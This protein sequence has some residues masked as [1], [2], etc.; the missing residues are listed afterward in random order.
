MRLR[1]I[2]DAPQRKKGEDI[3]DG[4]WP[5]V[6][7]GS[8]PKTANSTVPRPLTSSYVVHDVLSGG[9][10]TNT[11]NQAEGEISHQPDLLPWGAF[12]P[13]EEKGRSSSGRRR[14][15]V[16]GFNESLDEE[17]KE[18]R[19]EKEEKEKEDGQMREHAEAVGH[20]GGG[21][22]DDLLADLHEPSFSRQE[23]E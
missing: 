4:A 8:P 14:S 2:R 21:A 9:T 19:L 5:S 6:A 23:N 12:L 13:V 3:Q 22:L 1:C 18:A 10:G 7:L 15:Q 17:G 20:V 16:G 11:T